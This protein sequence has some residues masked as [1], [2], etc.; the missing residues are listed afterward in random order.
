MTQIIVKILRDINDSL[1]DS[2]YTKL[3]ENLKSLG[4]HL[5][6]YSIGAMVGFRLRKIC[7]LDKS[8]I[9]TNDPRLKKEIDEL[10]KILSHLVSW[11]CK[12]CNKTIETE[13]MNQLPLLVTAHEM[14]EHKNKPKK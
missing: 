3:S 9:P 4:H 10:I 7:N 12:I 6:K 2:N 1:N 13:N 5:D 11:K 14:S 8:S